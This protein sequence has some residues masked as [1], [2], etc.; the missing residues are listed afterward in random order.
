VHS[1][2]IFS[3]KAI[4]TKT[5][6]YLTSY[7]N[8]KLTYRKEIRE[9]SGCSEEATS[10]TT[11]KSGSVLGKGDGFFWWPRSLLRRRY[12]RDLLPGVKWM[13]CKADNPYL[14]AR[15]RNSGSTQ[16][17]V[18]QR[19]KFYCNNTRLF[20]FP[21][22]SHKHNRRVIN[23]TDVTSVLC[24]FTLQIPDKLSLEPNENARRNRKGY[25]EEICSDYWAVTKFCVFRMYDVTCW[26]CKMLESS[27]LL[28]RSCCLSLQGTEIVYGFPQKKLI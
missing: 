13:E 8:I 5:I 17:H 12:W 23:T 2:V 16:H 18:V 4:H 28:G 3:F 25:M 14:V 7:L 27:R 1:T 22:H 21:K 11:E 10:W 9:C 24:S 26:L 6:I 19:D 20:W 15:L